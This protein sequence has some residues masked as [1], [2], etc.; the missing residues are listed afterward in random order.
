VGGAEGEGGAEGVLKKDFCSISS[1]APLP[2]FPPLL[3]C[4]PCLR[5]LPCPL[6]R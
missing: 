3:P 5:F 6:A 2:P 1:P 4:L